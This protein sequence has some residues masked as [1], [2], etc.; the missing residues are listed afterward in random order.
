MLLPRVRSRR[1][2]TPPRP[3]RPAGGTRPGGWRARGPRA[4]QPQ[5]ATASAARLLLLGHVARGVGYCVFAIGGGLAMR[6]EC[7]PA[8]PRRVCDPALFRLGV[9]ARGRFLIEGRLAS[10]F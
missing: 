2:A 10:H 1:R 5:S 3:L 8:D 4:P 7:F 6:E 9:A